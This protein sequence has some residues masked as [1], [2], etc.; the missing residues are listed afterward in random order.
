[1][2]LDARVDVCLRGGWCW[3]RHGVGKCGSGHRDA[4]RAL[5]LAMRRCS[6]DTQQ[7]KSSLAVRSESFILFFSFASL[8]I[9]NNDN[10]D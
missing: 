10:E 9:A 3:G 6:S 4:L 1:M 2:S 7:I 5:A 8:H